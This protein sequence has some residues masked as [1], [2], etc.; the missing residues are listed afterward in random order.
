M[1]CFCASLPHSDISPAPITTVDRYGSVTSPRP[2]ASIRMP[3]SI[4]PPPSPPYA[5]SIGSA[6]QPS[7][8][9][10]FQI[11]GLKPSGSAATRRR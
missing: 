10:F 9:N 3:V 7:S 11:S 2:N 4:A 1:A 5:S 8:A 6:S